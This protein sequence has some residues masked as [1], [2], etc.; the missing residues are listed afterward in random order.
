MEQHSRDE[1]H[2]VGSHSVVN[3]GK[4]SECESVVIMITSG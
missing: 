4:L 2:I 1:N 3:A